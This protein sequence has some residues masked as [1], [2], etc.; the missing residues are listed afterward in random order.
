MFLHAGGGG[1]TG[2]QSNFQFA[3]PAKLRVRLEAINA[4][5]GT[6]IP[7]AVNV[8]DLFGGPV[9]NASVHF[10]VLTGGGSVSS[11]IVLSDANG[12]A[13]VQWTLGG[14]PG[15]NTLKA[16]GLGIAS[17]TIHGPRG[18]GDFLP[19][20]LL[21]G[22][23]SPPCSFP[24]QGFDPFIPKYHDF[25]GL[26]DAQVPSPTDGTGGVPLQTGSVVFTATGQ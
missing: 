16:F 23:G 18:D 21:Y 25:A 1:L 5:A 6:T 22:C 3:L 20:S 10:A 24:A 14:S 2:L 26:L 11:A 12:I 17:T 7:V 8:T 15:S 9:A 4:P 19:H 13:S